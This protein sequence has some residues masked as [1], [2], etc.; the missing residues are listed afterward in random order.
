MKKAKIFLIVTFYIFS[1]NNYF[2][3][4]ENKILD[5]LSDKPYT[6]K[7]IN[8]LTT[9]KRN[10]FKSVYTDEHIIKFERIDTTNRMMSSIKDSLINIFTRKKKYTNEFT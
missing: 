10:Y 3:I 5:I 9:L 6:E 2:F 8:V 7:E 4:V 1:I